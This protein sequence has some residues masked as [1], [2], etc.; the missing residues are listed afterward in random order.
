MEKKAKFKLS[1]KSI[2]II[3]IIVLVATVGVIYS[4]KSKKT[5]SVSVDIGKVEKKK[6]IQATTATGNIE[7]NY[8]NDIILNPA[9]KVIKV[10]VKEGQKVKKGDILVKLDDKEYKTQL[11][12]QQLNLQSANLTLSQLQGTST[13]NERKNAINAAEQAELT[14]QNAKNN[15][16]DLKKK[17]D[18][19]K[20]LYQGGY[21]SKNDYDAADKALKEAENS[22]KNAEL[23]LTNSKNSLS[24]TNASTQDK[25]ATQRN[26]IA[27]IAA[28]IKS[29]QDKINDCNV[30]ANV[31][32]KVVK[33][34][35]KEDQYPNT[36]DM[37]IIDDISK[38]KLSLDIN[39]YDAVN[40]KNGQKATVKIKGIDK[41][42]SAVVTE[43]GQVA[44]TKINT[45]ANS[46]GNQEF[47]INV[48]VTINDSDDK[49]RAGYEGDAEI[50][51]NEKNS[52]L[53]IGF[54]GIKEDRAKKEKYVYVVDGN[55][56]VSKKYIKNG[57]ETE[58]DVEVLEGLKEGEKYVINPPE[59]L[60]EGDIVSPRK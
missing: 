57:L 36:G 29:L 5:T 25:I 27:I 24:N 60:K 49:I 10:F 59:N 7:A 30:K 32:G 44:Q 41:K 13:I 20:T 58:Y 4:K 15:Y 17:F 3:L 16:S 43:V 12:K 18:Q 14:L 45:N 22:V 46:G 31:D 21:I 38:Y 6:L 35:A 39:Q 40:L 33:M 8:R 23:A 26:Q 9:Q 42:Y 50:V 11:E 48:K 55:N 54:D 37:I 52:S 28:D 51:L 2:I 47:K 53:S 56:K 1:K 34:D 19:N